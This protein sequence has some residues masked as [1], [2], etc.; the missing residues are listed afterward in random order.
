[1]LPDYVVHI[2]GP[3]VELIHETCGEL[4]CVIDDEDALEVLIGMATDH[5]DECGA[6][7]EEN[8]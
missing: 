3:A 6:S 5:A 8:A 2:N 1:M 7:D 4:V